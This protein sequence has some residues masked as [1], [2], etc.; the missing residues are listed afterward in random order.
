MEV[1]QKNRPNARLQ[2][3]SEQY[4]NAET[5]PRI[6][7]DHNGIKLESKSKRNYTDTWI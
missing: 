5:T 2:S 6:L 7:K 1:S 4:K 3:T